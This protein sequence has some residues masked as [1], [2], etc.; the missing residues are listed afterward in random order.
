[1][2]GLGSNVSMCMQ[3]DSVT[4]LALSTC[5]CNQHSLLKQCCQFRH[6]LELPLHTVLSFPHLPVHVFTIHLSAAYYK[7]EIIRY[8][9]FR[10]IRISEYIFRWI[11][12]RD[13]P[14]IECGIP[15]SRLT[16][17]ST[18]VHFTAAPVLYHGNDD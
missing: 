16:L 5:L 14:M 11:S 15:F 6:Y 12:L 4:A 3:C 1:M 13:F 9:F 18:F 10:I 2:H 17:F 8:Y 7:Y